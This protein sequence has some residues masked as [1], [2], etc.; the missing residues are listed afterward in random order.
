MIRAL[1]LTVAVLSV[2]GC[3]KKT[4]TTTRKGA[5]VAS[6]S[7]DPSPVAVPQLDLVD[8][9]LTVA[10]GKATLVWHVAG[11]VN[12]PI[13]K[14]TD[15]EW[16]VSLRSD[17][18]NRIIS[19]ATRDAEPKASVT[20]LSRSTTNEVALPPPTLS[21]TTV[22]IVAPLHLL[23]WS[24]GPAAWTVFTRR[25]PGTGWEWVDRIDDRAFPGE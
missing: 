1:V 7:S 11:P 8:A 6:D 21:G 16:R 22:E 3:G 25:D 20:L 12:S 13:P 15:Y 18:L 23:N 10:D 9:T 19:V 24:G 4:V 14:G 5:S 17:G 2:A